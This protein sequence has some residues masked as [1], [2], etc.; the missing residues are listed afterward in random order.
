MT[1]KKALWGVLLMFLLYSAYQLVALSNLVMQNVSRKQQHVVLFISIM[2]VY[3]LGSILL[4]HLRP[5]WMKQLWHIFH[6]IL[7]PTLLVL[8]LADWWMGGL[9]KGWR[10]FA[11]SVGETLVSPVLFTGI[12]LLQYAFAKMQPDA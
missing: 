1:R 9:P 6:V 7:I 5:L 8:G 2:L 11:Q 12:V 4:Q 10:H 3:G